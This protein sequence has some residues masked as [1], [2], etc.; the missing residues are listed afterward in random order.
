[1]VATH[2]SHRQSPITNTPIDPILWCPTTSCNQVGSAPP[3]ANHQLI[4]S[5]MEPLD[6]RPAEQR[7]QTRLIQAAALNNKISQ[8][9]ILDGY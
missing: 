5:P 8:L 7:P 4:H 3:F 6:G 9:S 1:M 2:S